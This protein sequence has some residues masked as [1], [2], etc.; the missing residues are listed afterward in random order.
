MVGTAHDARSALT[1]KQSFIYSDWDLMGLNVIKNV[2]KIEVKPGSTI[3]ITRP[4][5]T[6][7][8]NG[9]KLFAPRYCIP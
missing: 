3:T 4:G 8:V 2:G 7:I 9:K 1:P 6:L 5:G